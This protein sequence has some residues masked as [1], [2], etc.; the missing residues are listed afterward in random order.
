MT[1]GPLAKAGRGNHGIALPSAIAPAAPG[2]RSVAVVAGMLPAMDAVGAVGAGLVVGWLHDDV[3]AAD[4]ARQ[5]AATLVGTLLFLAMA[6]LTGQYRAEGLDRRI[7][8]IGRPAVMWGLALLLT[9]AIAYLWDGGVALARGWLVGW[10]LAG[11]ATLAGWRLGAAALMRRWRAQGR[12]AERIAVVGAGDH[13]RRLL[14]H[15]AQDSLAGQVAVLGVY[16]I[17]A[18]AGPGATI[19]G[20]IA[21]LLREA[22]GLG[23]DAVVVALPWSDPERIAAVCLQLR[24]LPV[25]VRLAPDLAAY[26]LPHGAPHMMGGRLALEMWGRPLRNWRGFVKRAEDLVVSAGLLVLLA[27]VMLLAAAAIRLDSPG[28]VLLR[29][30]RFGLGNRPIMILKFR[31]MYADRCD[32]TGR[33]ATL[34]GDPRVTRVGRFLRGSSIDEL[35]QLFNVLAGSM[36]LVGPRAHPVEMQVG[37][38]YYHEIVRHYAARH[39]M[40][41]GITG[42]AQVNG[43]RGLV[44]TMEKAQR[45]LDYDLHY[46]EHW[47]LAMD[48]RILVATLARGMRS[49]NAF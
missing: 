23:L 10:A 31:T 39:R 45:R 7:Q 19:D 5:S 8:E 4:F 37:G 24:D 20:R 25:D 44:D 48:A 21:E 42:L 34:R 3:G 15:L 35:P 43:Q 29:Q 1:R 11:A 30:R 17:D 2:R 28:P 36:S 41:P 33:Q 13:A 6:A 49:D 16:H 22:P 38:R 40:K 26:D 32:A 47:S 12:L 14:D 27:P 18:A 46:V 9:I